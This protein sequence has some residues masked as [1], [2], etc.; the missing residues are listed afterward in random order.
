MSARRAPVA[1]CRSCGGDRS[2]V[3]ARR[4]ARR[5][6]PTR[7]STRP[8][9]PTDDPTYPLEIVF[10]AD[11][12]LVQLGYALPAERIFDAEYPYFSSFS[13]A[14]MRHAADARRPGSIAG[15]RARSGVVR[16][17]GGEQRR[18]PAAQ[19]RRRRRSAR[20]ASI[21]RPGPAAA[22]EEVGRADDR[23]LL[24]RRAGDARC[25]T[26]HGPADVIV[27]NNVMAHVPDL[28]DFVGGFAHLLADDGLLTVENPYVRDLI[29]H[30]EFDTI[31]HE[32]YC[33][34]S[35]SAVDALMAPPRPAP[36]RRRV[37]PRP[38]RRHAALA[39]RPAAPT[40]RARC[41]QYLDDEVASGHDVGSSYY[42]GFAEPCARPA[43]TRCAPCSTTS[44]AGPARSPRTAPPPRARRCSTSPGS[45]PTGS[46]Y[47]V[48]RNVHKQGSLMPGCRLPI[49]PVEV[50][51][52]RATRRRLAPGVELRRRDRRPAARVRGG[53]RNVLRAGADAAPDHRLTA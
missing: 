40:A 5:R 49:R 23:R 39:H 47:V 36:Q 22:A 30:V 18:L 45:P 28:N 3:G 20:S 27:A 26:E 52:R 29:E 51:R 17:R 38:A 21:R 35:C 43:R 37:L 4:S 15:A 9:R 13:D 11:C 50:L 31:Y 25:A 16:R 8:R 19:L 41:Q 6:S 44:P 12:S 1:A 42:A 46:R 10:C 32:H 14:L 2:A 24:R 48:D 53:R 7:W 33:Y 34:F